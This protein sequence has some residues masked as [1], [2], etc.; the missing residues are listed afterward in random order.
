MV[1]AKVKVP[2][3]LGS[4]AG[5]LSALNVARN[6][7]LPTA[8]GGKSYITAVDAS[9]E[10]KKQFVENNLIVLSNETVTHHEVLVGEDQRKTT[11]IGITG[12]YTIVSTKD[13]SRETIS[14]VGDG[15]AIGTSV[16]SNIASTNALKN[17]LLRTFL[18][19]E[20]SVEDSAKNGDDSSSAK[21]VPAAVATAQRAA[22]PAAK[23]TPAKP[24][25]EEAPKPAPAPAAGRANEN[26]TKAKIRAEWV[27]TGKATRE[28]ILEIAKTGSGFETE[29]QKWQYVLKTLETGGA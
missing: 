24:A 14:G 28:R 26:P 16:A 10:V 19:T 23:K 17:A 3:V 1:E 6:G 4:I 2:E 7:Q 11:I 18:I 21:P 13:G 29:D 8:L 5:V 12:T 15:M 25:S 20:Q 22:K 27:E 9:A